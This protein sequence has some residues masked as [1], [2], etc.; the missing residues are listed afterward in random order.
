MSDIL[1]LLSDNSSNPKPTGAKKGFLNV[2]KKTSMTENNDNSKYKY[3]FEQVKL[4][5]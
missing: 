4:F 2:L 3:G 5:N 1:D